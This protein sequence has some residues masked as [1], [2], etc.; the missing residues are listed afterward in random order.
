MS[1]KEFSKT[2]YERFK[3]AWIY[4]RNKLIDSDGN[5]CFT[6]DSL[7]EMINVIAGGN[8]TTFKKVHV[9][10]YGF[11]KMYMGK[12]S[13]KNNQFNQR[14]ITPLK[15]H[16]ILS[17]KTHQFYDGNGSTCKVLFANEDKN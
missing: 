17:N 6:V 9:K 11:D 14:K 4:K 3:K 16:L 10:L 5:M 1:E 2:N 13:V 7:T 8:N 12:D 15:F